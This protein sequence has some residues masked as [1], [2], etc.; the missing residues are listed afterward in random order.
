MLSCTTPMRAGAVLAV[1]VCFLAGASGVTFVIDNIDDPGEGFNDPVLGAQ[2]L[3][4]LTY[5]ANIWGGLLR[6]AY[7]GQTITIRA[8][9]D[10][11]GGSSSSAIL[12]GASP[13][14]IYHD[15]TSSDPDFVPE[16]WYVD[17]LANNMH[18]ADLNPAEPEIAITFNSD[19]DNSTVLGSTD[20][21]YGTDASGGSDIDFVTVSLHEIGHG[22]NV[23]HLINSDGSYMYDNIEGIYDLFLTD[24]NGTA[25]VDMNRPQ[26]SN[27]ITS[28]NLFWSGSWAALG[29]GGVA[30][31]IYAPDPY[32][33]GSSVSHLDEGTY[34][35]ELMSPYYSGPDH[36]VSAV[37]LGLL[38]DM[39]W[40]SFPIP[41]DA[42]IDGKVDLHDLSLLA[43]NWDILEGK[44]WE[45]CDID[46][47]GAVDLDDLALLSANWLVG[48]EEAE[49]TPVPEPTT[50]ILMLAGAASI[51]RKR[52]RT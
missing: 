33:A 21:Y 18:G 4:A 20:W 13:L 25:V 19:V 26:R 31:Q 29:N 32:E 34:G 44:V 49:T 16:T 46:G 3:S 15:F 30:P 38:E 9:M 1:M 10:P 43:L 27:A 22:L 50:L 24:S 52:R 35:D 51:L 47:N 23:Y 17:A 37:E 48:V 28:D 40:D 6:D 42:N 8:Q 45:D 12:G 11:M 2:R 14:T 39:G 5:A 7:S 41:A 36:K